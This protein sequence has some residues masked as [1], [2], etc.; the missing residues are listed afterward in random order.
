MANGPTTESVTL[1]GYTID[2][3]PE[4]DYLILAPSRLPDKTE[5]GIQLLDESVKKSNLGLCIKC[6]KSY[7]QFLG[8]ELLFPNHDQHRVKDSDL[9]VEYYII[10]A[11][12]VIMWREP[13][14]RGKFMKVLSDKQKTDLE[15]ELK[16][17][18]KDV[19][20]ITT[21]QK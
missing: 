10:Q 15:T 16:G 7:I 19:A 14:E 1:K 13:V 17:E 2:W 20:K 9:D 3:E 12:R 5:A 8:K 18:G 11:S 21:L 6:A 4:L